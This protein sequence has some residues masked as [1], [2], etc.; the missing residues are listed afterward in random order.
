[1]MEASPRAI[2]SDGCQAF[3]LIELLTVICIIAMLSTLAVASLSGI[4]GA[5]QMNSA[6]AKA[7]GYID[8]VR[9][10]AVAHSTYAYVGYRVTDAPDIRVVLVA[11]ASNSGE[12]LSSSTDINPTATDTA[13]Q[14]GRPLQLTGVSLVRAEDLEM[15]KVP[16]M[17]EVESRGEKLSAENMQLTVGGETYT[18]LAAFGPSGA[19][20]FRK[21]VKKLLEF[22]LI[23][24]NQKSATDKFTDAGLVQI[25]G[26]TGLTRVYR[27]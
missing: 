27:Q 8:Q 5:G 6:L 17:P 11:V 10:F 22:A 16:T 1:M 23:Q 2:R 14:I 21:D 3:S 24:A 7:A 26:L 4:S 15:S 20:S 18:V 19:V 25:S 12:D 13:V 9:G